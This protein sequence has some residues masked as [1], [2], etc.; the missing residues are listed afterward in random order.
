ME[1]AEAD[2]Q[3]L[4]QGRTELQ[5]LEEIIAEGR[6]HEDDWTRPVNAYVK[7][8]GETVA[9]PQQDELHGL[10]AVLVLYTGHGDY[11]V[12]QVN[13]VSM[14]FSNV[15]DAYVG[16]I[17]AYLKH[18]KERGQ[19]GGHLNRAVLLGSATRVPAPD[20]DSC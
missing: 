18:I 9:Q 5:D 2:I 12:L 19:S 1:R 13:L 16:H 11:A 3:M 17:R 10:G 15:E 20:Q 14:G 6:G 7:L 4:A 8:N